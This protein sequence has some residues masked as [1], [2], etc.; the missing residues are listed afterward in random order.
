MAECEIEMNGQEEMT[1]MEE[2]FRKQNKKIPNS[3]ARGRDS[4]Q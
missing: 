1:M 4:V 3:K 2:M